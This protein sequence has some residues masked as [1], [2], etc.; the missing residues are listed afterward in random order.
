M[1]KRKWL[2][3]LNG[4]DHTVEVNFRRLSLA[5]EI[6]VDGKVIDAWG[7]TLNLAHRTFTISGKEAIIRWPGLLSAKSDLFV[8]GNR[9]E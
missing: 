6:I 8:D 9:I 2:V 3:N 5:G 4:Q 1:P 7:L